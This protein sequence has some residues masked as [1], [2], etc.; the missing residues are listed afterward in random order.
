MINPYKSF[1]KNLCVVTLNA[2]VINSSMSFSLTQEHN[3]GY[4]EN[5]AVLLIAGEEDK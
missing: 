2:S 3:V 4:A 1:R 5:N